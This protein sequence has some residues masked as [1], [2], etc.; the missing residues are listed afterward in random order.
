MVLPSFVAGL[1]LAT[2]VPAFR[3]AAIRL[4]IKQIEILQRGLAELGVTTVVC[5]PEERLALLAIGK[6]MDH[7][8]KAIF[9]LNSWST[10]RRWVKEAKEGKQPKRAGRPPKF[11]L[12]DI[13]LVVRLAKENICFG[14]GKIV[15][16][17]KKLGILIS[18]TSV[19]AILKDHGIAPAPD[20]EISGNGTWQ[21]FTANVDSLVAC[22]FWTKPIY[23]LFGRVDAYVLTFIH[24][25]TRKVWMSTATLS[26]DDGWCRQQA[27]NACMW[28]EDEGFDFRHLIRDHDSK[29]TERF[30]S[31][32]KDLSDA[33]EP[34]VLTGVRM[35]K[36]N[37]FC[38]SLIGHI[39]AE[40]LNHFVCFSLKQLDYISAQY[41]SYY[42]S[43]RPHQ[44][45]GIGNRILNPA[46][47]LPSPTGAVKRR[48]ILGGLL[49]HY[50]RDA[51]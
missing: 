31:I 41:L 7:H 19:K 1:L 12:E 20:R 5:T 51:G 29:F 26:P 30:D 42:N 4:L 38:E 22:D 2:I 25:G 35:P 10:Y 17:M 16:E 46:W 21:K 6:E 40:S 14:L 3:D 33:D 28:I 44:G 8:V 11:A 15:G 49:N 18:A 50:Y 48:K 37:S 24:L 27:I 34:V 32:F 23:S 43:Q 13:A 47:E 36:M 39:K 45:R 9:K